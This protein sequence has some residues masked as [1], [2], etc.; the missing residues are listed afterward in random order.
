MKYVFSV[1]IW[2][3][4]TLTRILKYESRVIKL[5]PGFKIRKILLT[6]TILKQKQSIST[7]FIGDFL[8]GSKILKFFHTLIRI[9]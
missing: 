8:L 2:F 9:L 4:K 1:K 7:E 6:L 3:F 5:N